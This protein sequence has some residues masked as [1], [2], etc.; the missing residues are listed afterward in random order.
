MSGL[1]GKVILVT[2]G[3]SGLGRACVESFAAS[4]ARVVIG[5]V[6][7]EL[8]GEVA[9]A[10]GADARFLSCDVTRAAD[11]AALVECAFTNFGRLDA[12]MSNA[13]IGANGSVETCEE[14]VWDRVIAVN[15]KGMFLIAKFAVPQLRAAGGGAI[16]NTAS[17]SGMWGEPDTVAYNASKGGVIAMTRAMAMDLAPDRIRV[18]ALCPGYHATGMPAEYFAAH[19]EGDEMVRRVNDLIPLRR[20]G[21]PGELARVAEFLLSDASSFMTG[22]V[23]VSDGGMTAGYPWYP[24]T[25]DGN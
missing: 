8:G 13:G 16:V 5:D 4:G 21:E 7:A 3:A 11:C 14:A 20:M 23:L 17:V 1:D 25:A 10:I 18:N 24:P 9:S 19:P 12:V 15:L 2:G 6:D 22:S